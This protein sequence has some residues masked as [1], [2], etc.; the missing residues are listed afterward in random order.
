MP[1]HDPAR[2][3]WRRLVLA[4]S[5]ALGTALIGWLVSFVGP[6]LW[7]TTSRAVSGEKPPVALAVVTDVDRFRSGARGS[8]IPEFIITRPAAQVSA[9]PNGEEPAGRWSW[10]HRLGGIDAYQTLIRVKISGA[11]RTPVI[12]DN[13]RVK[14]VRR[15][16]ALAAPLFSYLGLGSGQGVRYFEVD[17]D[18]RAPVT[19][20]VG[21]SGPGAKKH[22]PFPLRVTHSDVEVIDL[23]ADTLRCD[24]E[25]VAKLD[26]ESG[27]R[28]G[29]LTIDDHGKPF[30]TAAPAE[31]AAGD[32]ADLRY[33]QGD[34]WH[35]YVAST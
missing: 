6:K 27:T 7:N 5:A 30:H 20:Y 19:R 29:E 2:R 4:G 18:R 34:R 13:L 11:D 12:V 16:P 1:Q 22:D 24:C 25:W 15:G 35:R 17:L 32:A 33:W 9:P 31:N 23:L 3:P 21:G 10:A 14:V 28:A 26:W 8:F